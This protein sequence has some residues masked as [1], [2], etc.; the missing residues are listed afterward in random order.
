MN[1]GISEH[2]EQNEGHSDFEVVFREGQSGRCA[3]IAIDE[4]ARGG[5]WQCD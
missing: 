5:Q 2:N 1:C 3:V 4:S